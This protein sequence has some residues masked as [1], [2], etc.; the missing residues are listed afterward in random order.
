MIMM[1]FIAMVVEVITFQ[2]QQQQQRRRRHHHEYH[3]MIV[4]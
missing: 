2:K 1:P 4:E 3:I